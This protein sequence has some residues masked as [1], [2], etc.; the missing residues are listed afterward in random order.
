M[1][2]PR[3]LDDTSESQPNPWRKRIRCL[4]AASLVLVAHRLIPSQSDQG[5]TTQRNTHT[6]LTHRSR[7]RANI[8]NRPPAS[9]S[10]NSTTVAPSILPTET[11][12][13]L[14]ATL[15]DADEW[16]RDYANRGSMAALDLET[17]FDISSSRPINYTDFR[18][19]VV[20]ILANDYG[21]MPPTDAHE[22]RD[23]YE[24]TMGEIQ[25]HAHM[26]EVALGL[27]QQGHTD[28]ALQ[29]AIAGGNVNVAVDL[30]LQ[31]HRPDLAVQAVLNRLPEIHSYH[32]WREFFRF[33]FNS[34]P[35]LFQILYDR[36][37][38]QQE[39]AAIGALEDLKM[40]A[41]EQITLLDRTLP[42]ADSQN[43]QH[44]QGRRQ[45]EVAMLARYTAVIAWAME[46]DEE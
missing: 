24:W 8:F 6:T 36:F 16:G 44:L 22:F 14:G 12:A 32:Q 13:D 10:F 31:H 9:L 17:R 20:D 35:E 26:D 46:E 29:V 41:E 42:T 5:T 43:I 33:A 15:V 18:T 45:A 30:S 21:V 23:P 27:D 25:I 40:I 4:L 1:L 28:R 34:A 37:S 19:S 38:G 11:S 7:Q 3:S 2:G 39:M